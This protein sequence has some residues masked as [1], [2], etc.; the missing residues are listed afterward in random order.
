MKE[1][2]WHDAVV[3]QI[4]PR[5]FLDTN[6]DG[7]GDLQGIITKLDYL[8]TLGV[9]VLWLSP[10]YTSPM[11]DNGYDISNYEDIDA[12]FGTLDDMRELIAQANARGM[13]IMMDL[14]LNHTSDQHPWFIDARRNPAS[15][16]RDYYVWRDPSAFDSAGLPLAPNDMRAIFA[17]SAWAWDEL[18]GQYYFHLFT[19]QQ[20]D[21]NWQNP[22]L[23]RDIYRMINGWIDM[24]VR[25]FRLDVIDLIGKDVDA[26]ITTNGKDLHPFLQEMNRA[27]FG[28]H[29]LITVGE[30]WGAS[31]DNARLYSDPNSEE[32][33]MV[34]Q[35][36]HIT[37]T[38][39][40]GDK[41]LPQPF[42]LPAFKD[43]ISRWQ[44]ELA[45][46]GWNSLFWNNHDLPRAVSK[47]GCEGEHREASAKMLATAIHGLKGTPYVYQGE[48]LGMTNVGFES[49]D[50]YD[51]V[52]TLNFYHEKRAQGM[53]HEALMQAVKDN[54]RDNARTP[55]QW[56]D[57][58]NAGFTTG[59]P[60]LAVNDNYQQINAACALADKA[61]IFY[62]YQTLIRLR[63]QFL[64]L[65]Y[66]DFTALDNEHETV[67]AY[68][69]SYK[70]QRV[71]VVAH[72]SNVEYVWQVP[73]SIRGVSGQCLISNA[74]VKDRLGSECL[75][76]PFEAFMLLLE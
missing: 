11:V 17:G 57:S 38:W 46:N 44:T 7:I 15:P 19:P 42:S 33:S 48:E 34:F 61:S 16:Y 71:L 45:D 54:S 41:M 31:T 50:E 27:T 22:A 59:T 3:Y 28:R 2:W 4:Y 36:E 13:S 73:Q 39:K 47:Y 74:P 8:A 65:V 25:G 23:R 5:S 56:D 32:L 52:E 63:K 43:S 9:T 37:L 55:M 26:G 30:T 35:F 40:N 1:C 64:V 14:V 76:A 69:R 68:L 67:F 10:V 60:W 66:G 53:S 70:Q 29:D 72:F 24:G 21:L 51:D 12:Q 75:L 20:P 62:Y 58:P 49:L 6:G 18:S